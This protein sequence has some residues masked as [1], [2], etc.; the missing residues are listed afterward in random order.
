MRVV[1]A[2]CTAS[3]RDSACQ[4][5]HLY[6]SPYFEKQRHYAEM[7][8]DVWYIQ[9]AKYGLV[10]PTETIE[11]Y[12]ERAGELDNPEQWGDSIVKTLQHWHHPVETTIELLG[13]R[14]YVDPVREKLESVGFTVE[15]PLEGLG[16][17][18]RMSK[19]DEM[20]QH[21]LC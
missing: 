14:A 12:D 21:T 3:K 4:A 11:P 1:I 8:G 2:Q 17:G 19:L 16:I 18:E 5:K 7:K 13:G 6:D 10:V 15:E 9:S 20:Q